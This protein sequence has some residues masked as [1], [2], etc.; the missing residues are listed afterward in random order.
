VG[1]VACTAAKCSGVARVAST[2]TPLAARRAKIAAL[3]FEDLGFGGG[4][5]G[6]ELAQQ[7]EHGLTTHEWSR[8][9]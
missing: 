3:P 1:V 7:L 9:V 8:S 6:F 4:L 2:L 5:V